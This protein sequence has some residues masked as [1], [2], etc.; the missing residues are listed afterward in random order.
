MNRIYLPI[1]NKL[2][3]GKIALLDFVSKTVIHPEPAQ[4]HHKLVTDTKYLTMFYHI[5]YDI[6]YLFIL[7]MGLQ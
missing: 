7:K 5:L 6:F 3:A 2:K 4:T 1:L